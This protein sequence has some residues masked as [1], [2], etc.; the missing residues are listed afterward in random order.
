METR[1]RSRWSYD[2]VLK[3]GEP[4]AI[5]DFTQLHLQIF[6]LLA[7]HRHL[8]TSYFPAFAGM[9]AA[10][11]QFVLRVLAANPNRYLDRVDGNTY[12]NSNY[13]DQIYELT[14]RGEA[15]LRQRGIPIPEDRLGDKA[16]L[17]HSLMANDTMASLALGCRSGRIVWWDELSQHPRFPKDA[18]KKLH[19]KIRKHFG[20]GMHHAEFDYNNDSNGIFA[21]DAGSAYKFFSLEAE[22]TN[23]VNCSNLNQASFLKKLLAIQFI[24]DNQLYK[25]QWGLP[26]L[27]HL[28]VTPN[29]TR[30]ET[31]KNLILEET[32]GKGVSY[33]LFK[34]IP[35]M[36]GFEPMKPM[37]QLY[38]APWQRA[39]HP[40]ISIGKE[41]M[42]IELRE[43]TRPR[44][45]VDS[46]A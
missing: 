18:A 29:Q 23:R 35:T 13:R 39:G 31:M 8:R 11:V 24:M 43:Q 6:Q 32:N 42:Q 46:K 44:E 15:V 45:G 5:S 28:V 2:P 14:K 3:Q 25:K 21:I 30:I 17:S 9:N 41:V 38:T 20:K 10:Y 26:N 7:R 12:A 16:L 19:V 37:P 40:D 1:F 27:L 4:F 33:I 34:A 22:H 36:E